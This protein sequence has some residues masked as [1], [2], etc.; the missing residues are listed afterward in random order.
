M[1]ALL[2]L[3]LLLFACSPAEP[4]RVPPD[5][6]ATPD[7]TSPPD[8]TA[9]PCTWGDAQPG[10]SIPFALTH[11]GEARS[12]QIHLPTDYDCTPRSVIIGLHGYYGSGE[13]FESS[14][15]RMFDRID[16]LGHIGIFPDGQQM[17]PSGSSSWVTSFNDV[18][19]HHS[20]GP[21]GPTCTESSWD[22][23]TF[24]N[25][26]GNSPE[27]TGDC[28]WGTS[29][30]DDEG[31]LRA[32]LDHA[33][34]EWTLDADRIYLTGFS[35]GG[36]TA[37][38]LAWRLADV[39]A[40]TAPQHGFATNGYTQAPTTPM[41][42]FQVWGTADTTVDGHD[43]PSSDGMIYDGADETAAVWATAQGCEATTTTHATAFDG[44]EDWTCTEHPGCTTG[45]QVVSCS[46]SGAHIW[47]RKA[48]TNFALEAMLSFFAEHRRGG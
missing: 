26:A 39:L 13:G 42:L 31:F 32:I 41:G 46:W 10:A 47:G 37:Q 20:D 44:T 1:T 40:A 38:A 8:D 28:N 14:T 35:Q 6:T 2:L 5:D 3:A 33:H 30:S 4:L 25:C 22:Y 21:D 17:S 24:D 29:C 27:Q 19:S 36:Q 18:D 43:R 34:S 15:S 12:Y 16:E 11:G 45:A 23:G 48:G 9:T 7:D